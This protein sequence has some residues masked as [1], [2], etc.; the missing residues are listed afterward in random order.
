MDMKF[1]SEFLNGKNFFSDIKSKIISLNIPYFKQDVIIN[2]YDYEY[3]KNEKDEEGLDI[4]SFCYKKHLCWEPYQ[5]ELTKEILE[6]GNN[7]FI[8]I[9]SHL[10]TYS[11]ISSIYGNSTIAIDANINVNNIFRKTIKDNNLLNINILDI[12]IKNDT[13]LEDI[14]KSDKI[15]LI[16]ADVEGAEDLV[17]NIFKNKFENK[18]IDYAI[19]EITSKFLEKY[20]FIEDLY[21][22][23]YKIFNIG[24]SPQRNLVKDTNHLSLDKLQKIEIKED[25]MKVIKELEYGQSNFLCIS[26]KL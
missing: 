8:D 26:D 7:L 14:T 11:I 4:I 1:T 20:K 24:L 10:G 2:V 23:G 6:S 15:R 12:Y 18:Q 13:K 3:Y 19:F 9:G 16:K 25:F 22:I 17:Y 21:K 5:S